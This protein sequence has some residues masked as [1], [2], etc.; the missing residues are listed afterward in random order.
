MGTDG[1]G[2][3]F[4]LPLLEKQQGEKVLSDRLVRPPF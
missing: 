3:S 2:T 1:A 4:S